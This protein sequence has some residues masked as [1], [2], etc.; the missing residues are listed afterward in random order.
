M[1]KKRTSIDGIVAPSSAK[2]PV[3]KKTT[4]QPE[5]L[6]VRREQPK[7]K[8]VSHDMPQSVVEDFADNTTTN[9]VESFLSD[10]G[11]EEEREEARREKLAKANGANL[12]KKELKKLKKQER[13]NKK[14]KGRVKRTILTIIGL[15]L[16][17]GLIG[18]LIIYKLGD[19]FIKDLTGGDGSLWN[20]ITAK[21]DEPLK[22]D[23]NGRTNILAFGTS[24]YSMED[25]G[26]DGFQLADSI[27]IISLDQKTGDVKLVSLPRDLRS[28]ERCTA[29]GKLNE[30]YWCS[31]SQY[32]DEK[33][34]GQYFMNA[35]QQITGLEMQYFVHLNWDAMEK[36][37][38]AISGVDVKI[39]Y[40]YTPE[41]CKTDLAVI[42]SN[43]TRGIY[44]EWGINYK[45]GD[46]VHLTGT[47]ATFMAR[48]RGAFGGYGLN[49]N[50]S[51]EQNQQ[52]LLGAIVNK[53]KT[54]NFAT[55]WSAALKVKD[56]IG[57]NLRM[58]FQDKEYLTI[59]HLLSKVSMDTMQ[60]IDIQP[61]FGYGGFSI[62]GGD[63]CAV[64]DGSDGCLSFVVPLAGG[65]NY[66]QIQAFIKQK[67]SSD[68][69]VSEGAVIDFLNGGAEAGEA[70]RYKNRLADEG[71]ITGSVGNA[72]GEYSGVVV[73]MANSEMNATKRALE[74]Y[75]GVEVKR[76][77][78]DGYATDADFVVVIGAGASAE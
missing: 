12:S 7:S 57:D 39:C 65:M 74:D 45:I 59:Y 25:S 21:P 54:T 30:T 73:F 47:M 38:D 14:K 27:M 3:V 75:Y 33:K 46:E 62:Y 41:T 70:M 8:K 49:G 78:P 48:A 67:I 26:H 53:A 77:L 50:W 36:V 61:L 9:D 16:G 56:A 31:Y 18:V 24:G 69:V 23:A 34:A 15:I 2:R 13:K 44:D 64:T 19:D 68:P 32:E 52:A 76:G 40:E 11:Y 22:T 55:D 4:K 20:V 58:N 28:P 72:S 29:T 51:R 6:I 1:D 42:W 66:S 71:F 63:M 43:D 10:L 37:V 5:S 17:I 35:V 60:S